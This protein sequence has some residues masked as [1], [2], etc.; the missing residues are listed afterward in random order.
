MAGGVG[1]SRAMKS[2]I[3]LI[4]GFSALAADP[5]R[6]RNSAAVLLWLLLALPE[7]ALRWAPRRRQEQRLGLSALQHSHLA[8]QLNN[9]LFHFFIRCSMAAASGVGE[10]ALVPCAQKLDSCNNNATANRIFYP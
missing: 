3:T 7:P 5:P 6:H 4:S 1:S 8:L 2:P 9:A 10:A